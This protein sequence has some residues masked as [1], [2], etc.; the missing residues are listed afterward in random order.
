MRAWLRQ[1][2]QAFAAALRRLARPAGLLSALVIGVA[3]ALPAGSYALLE[4]LR[5]VTARL[6][7]E[8]QISVFLA[9]DA[10]RADVDSVAAALRRDARV[11]A[12]RFV[13]RE[14]ALKELEQVQGIAEVVAA[15]GRNPLP[16]AFVVTAGAERVEALAADLARLPGVAHVQA[17][18]AWARRL[19]ALEGI[20]RLG[21]AVLAALLGAGLVAVTFNTIRLQILTQRDEIEVAKLIG[22]S[23]RFIRRPFYYFG[24][25]QGLAGGAL[26]MGIVAFALALLNRE[27]EPLAASYG[28][29]FRLAFPPLYDVMA[30][31]VLAGILGW[32]GAQLSVSRHLRAIEPA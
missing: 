4:S 7:L 22:A 18:A 13:P 17:D 5:G 19:A 8:P 9:F 16:D 11:G 6:S 29:A 30:V 25:L 2:R 21:L 15:I 23:D 27:V 1:H 24:L 32:L 14:Q 31:V 20:G 26:A 12:V 10:K 3:L 28:S